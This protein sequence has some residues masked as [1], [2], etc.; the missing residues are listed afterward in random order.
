MKIV[1]IITLALSVTV[2][3]TAASAVL[4]ALSEY[5]KTN[6]SVAVMANSGVDN[7]E[8]I[9][10]TTNSVSEL[11]KEALHWLP[12]QVSKPVLSLLDCV[13]IGSKHITNLVISFILPS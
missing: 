2:L 6:A 13:Y 1:K 9:N 3:V 5:E 10:K 8:S 12:S 4:G 11:I 7:I